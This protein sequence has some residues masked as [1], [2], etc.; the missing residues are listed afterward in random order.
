MGGQDLPVSGKRAFFAPEGATFAE[1]KTTFR[2]RFRWTTVPVTSYFGYRENPTKGGEGF[3]QGLDI[4]AP[5]GQ[6]GLFDVLRP[7][8]RGR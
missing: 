1:L 2:R 4:G 7:G 5:G 6:P 3:H 8:Q